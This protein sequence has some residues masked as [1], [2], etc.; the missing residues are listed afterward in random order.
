MQDYIITFLLGFFGLSTG[1][2]LYAR[3]YYKGEQDADKRRILEKDYFNKL[4]DVYSSIT[5][6]HTQPTAKVENTSD[7][8]SANNESA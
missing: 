6:F 3:G 2:A 5:P 4:L 7:Q 1:L 8:H